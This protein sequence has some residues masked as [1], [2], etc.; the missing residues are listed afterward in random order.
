MEL[1]RL[2]EGSERELDVQPVWRHFA[3]AFNK[4]PLKSIYRR[5]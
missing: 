4:V 2:F 3:I 1:K 5:T